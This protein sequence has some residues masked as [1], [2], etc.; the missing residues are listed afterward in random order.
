MNVKMEKAMPKLSFPPFS[1]VQGKPFGGAHFV[2]RHRLSPQ[3]V[4]H[5]VV[6]QWNQ[7]KLKRESRALLRRY[8]DA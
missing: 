5:F 6:T 7:G 4:T 2:A 3:V 8:F 1:T